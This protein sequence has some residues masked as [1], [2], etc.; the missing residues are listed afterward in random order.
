M[1]KKPGMK[2]MNRGRWTLITPK[3]DKH[4]G[5]LQWKRFY[6]PNKE[7]F[8]IFKLVAAPKGK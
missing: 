3:G 4:G 8:V 7:K 2:D 1:A 6:G 5:L